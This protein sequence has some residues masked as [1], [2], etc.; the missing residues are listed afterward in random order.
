[1]DVAHTRQENTNEGHIVFKHCI[2]TMLVRF[3][4]STISEILFLVYI[5]FFL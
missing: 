1:M 4:H 2:T 3:H 5:L